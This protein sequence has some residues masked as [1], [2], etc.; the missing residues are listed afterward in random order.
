MST[1]T[2]REFS[3]NP[4]AFFARVEAGETI[5]V[6]K[7]GTVVAVLVPPPRGKSRYDELVADGTI[8]PAER[9]L[10]TDDLD[11]FTRIKVPE[12]ARDPLDV[13]FEMREHER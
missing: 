6:T 13:L 12:G 4:S 1:V 7:H 9:G 10:T 8:R 11:Q 2:I 3:C 5:E